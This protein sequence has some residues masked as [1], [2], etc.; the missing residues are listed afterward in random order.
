LAARNTLPWGEVVKAMVC[1]IKFSSGFLIKPI[2]GMCCLLL[3]NIYHIYPWTIPNQPEIKEQSSLETK[4]TSKNIGSILKKTVIY[5]NT[6]F[7]AMELVM[8]QEDF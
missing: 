5:N 8:V 4:V 3:L 2:Y 7:S 1:W 6:N